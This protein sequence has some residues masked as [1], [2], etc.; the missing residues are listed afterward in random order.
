MVPVDSI[1]RIYEAHLFHDHATDAES[2]AENPVSFSRI[3]RGG[4]S[5]F[6]HNRALLLVFVDVTTYLPAL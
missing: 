4:G 6:G 5:E 1:A 3:F 2:L